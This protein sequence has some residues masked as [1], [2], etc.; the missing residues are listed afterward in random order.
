VSTHQGAND[1]A[2]LHDYLNEF[3][4]RLNRRHAHGLEMG[5]TGCS[6]LRCGTPRCAMQT[7]QGAIG[8]ARHLRPH[9]PRA[10]HRR[11]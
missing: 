3:V 10:A 6:S 11:A 1:L 8:R 9:P 2:H 5:S 4:F 7:S